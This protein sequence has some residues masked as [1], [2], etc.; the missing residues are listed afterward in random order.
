MTTEGGQYRYSLLPP[1]NYTVSAAAAGLR[2]NTQ[3]LKLN[4]DQ[5]RETSLALKPNF[6]LTSDSNPSSPYFARRHI[7]IVPT[8][9][10]GYCCRWY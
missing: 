3:R 9:E 10:S 6:Q 2:S 1:G 4:V 8:Q 7:C 5:A